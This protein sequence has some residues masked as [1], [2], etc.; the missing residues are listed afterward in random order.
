MID[1]KIDAIIFD[2]GGVIINLNYDLS[3]KSFEELGLLDFKKVYSQLQQSS[4]FDDYET[5]K[6]STQHFINK[7]L[8]HLPQGTSPNAVVAA[9]N[10]MIL[11]VP[12]AKIE[13]LLCLKNQYKTYLLS[14]TNEIHM[15][16]VRIEWSKASQAN[17]ETHF[18]KTYLSY[19]MGLRKPDIEIFK[20]VCEEQGLIPAKTLFIDDSIQHIEGARNAGLQAYHLNHPEELYTLFS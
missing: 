12:K 8:T 17:L 19:Q 6:I 18:E 13:L 4:L 2:L 14:N 20:F 10:K 5:G 15:Q 11:D 16:K 3:T 7:L 1:N 9:W